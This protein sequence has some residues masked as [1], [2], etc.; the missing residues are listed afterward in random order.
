MCSGRTLITA[1]EEKLFFCSGRFLYL[2][3]YNQ[4]YDLHTPAS[5]VDAMK[6]VPYPSHN[7]A[8]YCLSFRYT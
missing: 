3:G 6:F 7:V 1:L 8:T 2:Y 5:T 4:N